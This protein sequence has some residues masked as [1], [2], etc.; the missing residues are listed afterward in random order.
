M[1]ELP[2]TLADACS[3]LEYSR[4]MGRPLG[5]MWISDSLF[6]AKYSD[7]RGLSMAIARFRTIKQKGHVIA[8]I[9]RSDRL[10]DPS[11]DNKGRQVRHGPAIPRVFCVDRALLERE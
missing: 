7:P 3:L 4:R 2:G 1:L 10:T 5:C 9:L 11:G 8:V 6:F